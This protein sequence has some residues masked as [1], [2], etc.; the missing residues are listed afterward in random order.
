MTD[1]HAAREDL[2][3]QALGVRAYYDDVVA[4]LGPQ[5]GLSH[6]DLW[7]KLGEHLSDAGARE[8]F[9]GAVRDAFVAA[10]RGSRAGQVTVS[11]NRIAWYLERAG[12]TALPAETLT[13]DAPDKWGRA[14]DSGFVN[15]P[16]CTANGNFVTQECD[17]P[18][19]GRAAVAGWQRT[20]N[21]RAAGRPGAL[22]RGWSCWA[23]TVLDLGD[24]LAGPVGMAPAAGRV[25]MSGPAEV[26]GWR[27]LD[28]AE[29]LVAWPRAD[30]ST[31]MP[32]L[33]GMLHLDGDGF[34]FTRGQDE[35]WWYDGSGRPVRVRSG[36]S[37]IVL[38]WADGRLERVGY[39]R[40]GRFLQV[41][42]DDAGELITAVQAS[43]GRVV[44]Y[45]YDNGMLVAVKGG[46][47]GVQRYRYEGA[48]LA[49]AFDADSVRLFHNIYDGAG[50][51][52]TQATP[53]GRVARFGYPGGYRTLV[54][55]TSG[56]SGSPGSAGGGAINEYR[57]DAA[58]RLVCVVDDADRAFHRVFDEAGRLRGVR[59]R[60]GASWSMEYDDAGNLTRRTGPNG[61]TEQW[62]WDSAGRLG[63]HT[64]PDGSRTR[65]LYAGAARTPVEIVDAAGAVTRITVTDDDLPSCIV[66][67]DGVSTH[68]RWDGDGQLVETRVAGGGRVRLRYDAAGRLVGMV[69]AD[70]G[71]WRWECDEA[72]RVVAQDAPDGTRSRFTHT[73]AGRRDGYLDPAGGWWRSRYGPHGLVEQVTDPTGSSVGFGY[74]L[75]GNTTSIVAPDGQVFAFD[76]DGLSRL[77]AVRN[78]V[79]STCQRGYDP[80]GR[81]TVEA[82]ADGREWRHG[83]DAAGQPT[84]LTG[85]DGRVW[86][87]GYD[88]AG[89]VVSE[90]EP[91]GATVR[92]EYDPAGR[93][94]AV[95]DAAGRR[96]TAEWTP[97]GRLAAQV[98]PSGRRTSYGY[99]SAGRLA[100]TVSPSGGITRCQH[101]PAGRPT[102]LATAAGRRT[103]WEYDARGDVRAIIGPDGGRAE[104]VRNHLGLPTTV[105][106]PDGAVHAYTYDAR[107]GM[108]S[109]VDPLGAVTRYGYDVRGQL[110]EWTDPAGGWHEL[111]YDAVGWLTGHTDPLGRTTSITRTRSGL[112]DTLRHADGTGLRWWHDVAGRLT[113]VGL[114][115]E[116]QPRLHYSYDQADRLTHAHQTS[117]VPAARATPTAVR[118]IATTHGATSDFADRGVALTYDVTG[119]LLTRTT[120][121]G[122]LEW[123]CDPDGR[124]L[125]VGQPG[126]AP[127]RHDYDADGHLTAVEHPLLGRRAITRDADGRPLHPGRIVER[128]PAG[129]ITRLV[130][131]GREMRF[132]YDAAGQLVTADGP[133]GRQT[134]TWDAAG[135]LRIETHRTAMGASAAGVDA[136]AADPDAG[137]GTTDRWTY[138]A[139]GQ[140][141]EHQRGTAGPPAAGPPTQAGQR[142][143]QASRTL[144]SYDA[145]GR[146]TGAT[147][148]AGTRTYDWD[149][150]GR[151]SAVHASGTSGTDQTINWVLDA[152]GDPLQVDGTPLLWDPVTWPGT[153]HS[154]GTTIY[155]HT[156]DAI[157]VLPASSSRPTGPPGW[158]ATDWQ[159]S[160]GDSLGAYDPWGLPVPAGA[161]GPVASS[162]A[163]AAPSAAPGRTTTPTWPSDPAGPTDLPAHRLISLGYRGELTV[164][165]LVWQR[166]R[167]LDPATRSFLSPD[168]LEHVPGM[169][170]A[171]NPYHYAWNDPVG[172]LDPTGLQPISDEA[173][174]AYRSQQA[175]TT[176]GRAWHT[177]KHDPWGTLAAAGV[178]TVGV[179]LCF[180]PFAPLAAAGSGVLFGAGISAG[181]GLATGSFNPR[182]VA[183]SGVAGGV[184]A[185]LGNYRAVSVMTPRLFAPATTAGVVSGGVGDLTDQELT[186]PGHI[187]VESLVLDTSTGG[188]L[189][190]ASRYVSG[191]S[192]AART[193]PV[194]GRL[195]DTAVA[196]PWAGHEVLALKPWLTGPWNEKINDRWIDGIIRAKRVVYLGSTPDMTDIFTPR[197]GESVFRVEVRDLLQAGYK[198]VGDYLV[199]PGG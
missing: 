38:T 18:L 184:G 166:E 180:T 159:Q 165:G 187:D 22:G 170:G 190:G 132:A 81:L 194:I 151:I 197:I 47:Q 42:W 96:S 156:D 60:S 122:R 19:P 77:T 129:R 193:I 23:D 28:G 82:D 109:A 73:P 12:I 158:Y 4:R 160:L 69:G 41:G 101:D 6:P 117:A 155:A 136:G 198:H 192:V 177:I 52:L 145:A 37:E 90:T 76:Y 74:D 130:D 139:A 88:P 87:R 30:A 143:T 164:D 128:D 183:I 15:D 173:Y 58:G 17:L 185:G 48:L 66:D 93:L 119:R 148:P 97:G 29:S 51:V 83:Y 179:G 141:V 174:N 172:R 152:L 167:L 5:Y 43:D 27:G 63:T 131:R 100:Q 80:D 55:D 94:T 105:T 196:Q 10:D 102:T 7:V 11:D 84:E 182:D 116:P 181:I 33:G 108:V 2:F 123:T 188:L 36:P 126:R 124:C 103:R 162:A 70:G 127:V 3:L 121:A 79:G 14:P 186:H 195:D 86:R 61:S 50:R 157:G 171:G 138:D 199:P 20:Y 150:L 54:T 92:Y 147:G 149:A 98:T 134:L 67:P 113:G 111:G 13:V 118:P 120:A 112:V 71:S 176:F 142:T 133:W 110:R 64:G 104:I 161:S 89:R 135:R 95:I 153:V 91:D 99:D 189:G 40:S 154:L 72:G 56:T 34:R 9:V 106:G 53:E 137:A 21:S 1:A 57:H 8:D 191:R 125:T 114:P 16:V 26:L 175:K 78:P 178:V 140:L 163:P 68:L 39:P 44:R 59:E 62:V 169:P 65:W 144:F 115:D 32:R 49:E 85:P 25:G 107:G 168:P 45:S 35:S 146:R 75:F 46:P 31:A 24:D